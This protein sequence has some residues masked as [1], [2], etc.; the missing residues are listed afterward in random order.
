MEDKKLCIFISH[1]GTDHSYLKRLLEEFETYNAKEILVNIYCTDKEISNIHKPSKI[2][3]KYKYFN[4]SIGHDLVNQYKNDLVKFVD[5][6]DLFMYSE[7]DILITE[8]NI[9]CFLEWKDILF[10]NEICGF[11]RYEE[12]N[13][14]KYF[15]DMHHSFPS[16]KHK[17]SN[18]FSI[19]NLHQGCWILTKKQLIKLL[20]YIPDYIEN[21]PKYG[22]LEQGATWP[23]II[24]KFTKLYPMD[25]SKL[26]IHHLPNKYVNKGEIWDDP[27]AWSETELKK[28]LIKNY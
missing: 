24:G 10:S 3:I 12:K 8:E 14:E 9:K 27:G 13:G 5:N 16:L 28:E 18:L 11:L 4:E 15:I 20:D 2:G 19:H 1:F 22:K 21:H 25:F 26:M 17:T 7:D 23:F 6:F